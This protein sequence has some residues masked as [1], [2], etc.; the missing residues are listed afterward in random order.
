MTHVVANDSVDQNRVGGCALPIRSG[1]YKSSRDLR[2][3]SLGMTVQ[4]RAALL[5]HGWWEGDADSVVDRSA[6]LELSPTLDVPCI[7]AVTS[8]FAPDRSP[9]QSDEQISVTANIKA[10]GP[11]AQAIARRYQYTDDVVIA[12]HIG[13]AR[14]LEEDFHN[15][16]S[17]VAVI[18][19]PRTVV[20]RAFAAEILRSERDLTL[21]RQLLSGLDDGKL[22]FGGRNVNEHVVY[23]GAGI[24]SLR[25]FAR[26]GKTLLVR[27]WTELQTIA[28]V[29]GEAPRHVTRALYTPSTVHPRKARFGGRFVV[30]WDPESEPADV[31]LSAAALDDLHLATYVVCRN[32]QK[33][34]EFGVRATFV[35]AEAAPQLLR[36]ALAIV[37]ADA[38]DPSAAVALTATRAPLAIAWT[39]GAHEYVDG[40]ATFFPWSTR[41]IR[42][43]TLEALGSKPPSLRTDVL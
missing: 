11:L 2:A 39:S 21:R 24:G 1:N 18:Q 38:S 10:F 16:F 32:P 15:A 3:S 35:E 17:V 19:D 26:L 7:T 25:A 4:T 8:H 37:V 29:L 27:S 33:A 30:I 9:P 28:N 31:A 40:A 5:Q 43:A 41:S 12:D 23:E 22:S 13:A 20:A 14:A 34:A 6:L 42:N 36:D